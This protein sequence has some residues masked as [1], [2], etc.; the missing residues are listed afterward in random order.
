M[1]K[2]TQMPWNEAYRLLASSLYEFYLQHGENTGKAL[3]EKCIK[4]KA[5]IADKEWLVNYGEEYNVWSIDPIQIFAS[6]TANKMRDSNRQKRL[7]EFLGIMEQRPIETPI[8]YNGCPAPNPVQLLNSRREIDHPKIWLL[9]KEAMQ[10]GKDGLTENLFDGYRKWFGI[11]VTSL[12]IFLFWINSDSFLSLDGN[13]LDLLVLAGK[14]E[15][16]PND[17]QSYNTLLEKE[18]TEV[19]RNLALL[20]VD[21]LD[22]KR[23]PLAQRQDLIDYLGRQGEELLSRAA[24]EDVP[25]IDA[26]DIPFEV[27]DVRKD[28]SDDIRQTRFQLLAIRPLK[29][30]DELLKTLSPGEFYHF[31]RHYTFSDEKGKL[32]VAY[33][34]EADLTIYDVNPANEAGQPKISISAIVGKNGAG[35]SNLVELLI[36]A[37]NNI[38]S[39]YY[40]QEHPN[41]TKNVVPVPELKVELYFKLAPTTIYQVK[42]NGKDVDV[43]LLR[44]SNQFDG[45]VNSYWG[46]DVPQTVLFYSTLA[47]YSLHG[48]R[49]NDK[50]KPWLSKLFHKNDAY[51]VPIVL[52]P[53]RENGTIN[54]SRLFGQV[55]SRLV[56]NLL[57]YLGLDVAENDDQKEALLRESFRQLTDTQ[58]AEQLRFQLMAKKDAIPSNYV[59]EF[60]KLNFPFKKVKPDPAQIFEEFQKAYI[61]PLPPLTNSLQDIIPAYLQ[62]KLVTMCLRYPQYDS[63]FDREALQFKHLPDLFR[64]IEEDSSH[65][66]YKFKRVINFLRFDIYPL[67]NEISYN[68]EKLSIRINKVRQKN[69]K[70]SIDTLIPPSFYTPVIDL[71]TQEAQKTAPLVSF[72]RLSSGEKQRIYAVS[73]LIYH[74]R[75]L[76]SVNPS[77]TIRKYSAVNVIFDEVELYFHPE[78]QRTYI[79]YMLRMIR[80]V[81][82]SEISSINICF[83]THSPFIL[84]DIPASNILFLNK[85]S[86]TEGKTQAIPAPVPTFAAN[87]HELLVDGFF[88]DHTVGEF[89]RKRIENILEFCKV[90][91]KP[92]KKA[93]NQKQK[94]AMRRGLQEHKKVIRM[95]G[96]NYI[97]GIMENHLEEVEKNWFPA[98]YRQSRI[99]RLREELKR[100]EELQTAEEFPDED[101]INLF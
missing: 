54:V 65:V 47:N 52:A 67:E 31:Y 44:L 53:W 93:Q 45:E 29:M 46:V 80:R 78:W 2:Q 15:V 55:K 42:I 27:V 16:R 57:E 75:N 8:D 39:Q 85:E 101:P 100:E 20:A 60:R 1:T 83:V 69:P 90:F 10:K 49:S 66:A 51:Q 70:L 33:N 37:I 81:D 92:P 88:M 72:Q 84:S 91:G 61:S 97:R 64:K 25:R 13:T 76:N 95:I 23:L 50:E 22:T 28:L 94:T 71:H 98:S 62:K 26:K 58:R 86:A 48:L 74:L 6:F 17:F 79:D 14:I 4:D 96:E 38:A 7:N 59:D 63:F 43:F 12:T 40:S 36:M 41:G 18:K 9:F 35:K 24:Q 73:S 30:K 56:V 3:Y 5:F 21:Q 77:K 11:Q 34:P 68:I 19:Y 87:I 99:N 32:H 89:A 82:V